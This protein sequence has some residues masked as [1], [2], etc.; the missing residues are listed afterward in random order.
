MPQFHS[1]ATNEAGHELN[2]FTRAYIDTPC[3][4]IQAD[5]GCITTL[6]DCL[7]EA[8]SKFGTVESYLGDDGLLHV[9]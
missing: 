3:P 2:E 9:E 4:A 5:P 7:T 6:G 1:T 8:A